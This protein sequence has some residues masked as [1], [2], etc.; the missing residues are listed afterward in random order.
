LIQ[1]TRILKENMVFDVVGG[2]PL[3]TLLTTVMQEKPLTSPHIKERLR[4]N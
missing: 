3:L 2:R 4:E 1:G